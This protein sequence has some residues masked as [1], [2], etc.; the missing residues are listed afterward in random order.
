M[1]KMTGRP[2][3]VPGRAAHP[4]QRR[5]PG[6]RPLP[7]ALLPPGRTRRRS[8][9]SSTPPPAGGFVPERRGKSTRWRCRRQGLRHDPPGWQAGGGHHH[10]HR[11]ADQDLIKDPEIA[12]IV[13]IIPDEARTFGMDAMFPSQKD[14][15]PA[16]AALHLRGRQ[17]DAGLQGERARPDPA[18]GINE[19]GSTASFTAVAPRTPP[20]ASR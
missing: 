17:A 1:R 2:E 10:G 5:G 18:R 11:P 7:A 3:A 13:P 9:T 14:L 6:A 4:D 19:A 8:S 20:T 12:P 15:Q 16:R